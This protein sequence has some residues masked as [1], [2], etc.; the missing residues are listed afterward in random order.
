MVIKYYKGTFGGNRNVLNQNL[1]SVPWTNTTL[2]THLTADFS[3]GT[4]TV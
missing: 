3:R 2:K 4:V 1:L